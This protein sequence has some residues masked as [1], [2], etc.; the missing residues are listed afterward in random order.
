MKHSDLINMEM[1]RK[2]KQ[3]TYDAAIENL[4]DH[5]F[6]YLERR[7]NIREKVRA[8]HIFC[9]IVGIEPSHLLLERWEDHFEHWFAFDYRNIQ[10]TTMFDRF[11]RENNTKW[12]E[13]MLKVSALFLLITLEPVVVTSGCK[14]NLL[15]VKNIFTAQNEQVKIMKNSIHDI[16]NGDLLLIRKIKSGFRMMM[17]G[18]YWKIDYDKA[19]AVIQKI[20]KD[21]KN[22][23][24][25]F[26]G[27][28]YR[29]FLKIN[30]IHYFNSLR[31]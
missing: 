8:R 5:Y 26:P 7:I 4:Y 10:G 25:E 15:E 2:Q 22:F 28:A 16:H 21:F 23:Q 24:K 14:N 12:T 29:T 13:P 31:K 20:E 1:L 18:P 6:F 30:G 9:N 27:C 3:Q 19:N 17:I 11:L